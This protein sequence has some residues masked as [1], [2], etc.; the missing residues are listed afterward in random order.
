MGLSLEAFGQHLRDAV[1]AAQ[2]REQIA[3]PQPWHGFWRHRP[4]ENFPPRAIRAPDDFQGGEH[5]SIACTQTELSA[6]AQKALVQSWCECLPTLTGVRYVWFQSRTP[7]ALFEAACQMPA[8][9]GLYVKW[10]G[11]QSLTPLAG[12]QDLRYLYLGSSPGIPSLEPLTGLSQLRWL[13]LDNLKL[14]TDLEPLSA[15]RELE[16]LGFVGAEGKRH[17]V[18]T[19]APLREL[20]QLRW[21]HLGALHVADGSLRP[22]ANLTNLR[23]LGTGNYFS[24]DEFAWLAE[25]LPNTTSDW[26]S[27]FSDLGQHGIRCPRCKV[28]GL[29]LLAGKGR[30]SICPVCDQAKL[31]DQL[32]RF[33][34]RDVQS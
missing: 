16:G 8:L 20:T 10:S 5:L 2:L 7:Q 28:E 33:R 15:L 29:L 18:P 1:A 4:A 11:I 9:E 32:A 23:W 24:V 26:L 27:A 12:N 21:L 3:G 17:M 6:K 30:G 13:Q 19:L 22:L 14:I 34:P 31:A 25:A